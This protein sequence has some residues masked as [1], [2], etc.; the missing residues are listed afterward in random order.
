[1][2][3]QPEQLLASPPLIFDPPPRRTY[4]YLSDGDAYC[5]EPRRSTDTDRVLKHRNSTPKAEGREPG[6]GVKPRPMV[7]RPAARRS[8]RKHSKQDLETQRNTED[9]SATYWQD[10]RQNE[11]EG[12]GLA[13]SH[14]HIVVDSDVS[15]D[16]EER[17][18][19]EY[20]LELNE[21]DADKAGLSALLQDVKEQGPSSVSAF[22]AALAE[23]RQPLRSV[24]LCF[25]GHARA[26]KTS[27]L[28]ALADRS[29]DPEQP[30]THGPVLKRLKDRV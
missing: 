30:S 27:T 28:R 22:R 21:E 24:K 7:A 26:G 2:P 13:E 25:V 29:F 9:A 14:A 4:D 3:R 23:G 15:E 19:S 18:S 1:M 5:L 8:R 6:R 20:E 11:A 16:T 12:P 10:D 17:P